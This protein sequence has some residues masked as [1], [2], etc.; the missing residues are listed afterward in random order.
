MFTLKKKQTCTGWDLSDACIER[1]ELTLCLLLLMKEVDL[2]ELLISSHVLSLAC[3][4]VQH[5]VLWFNSAGSLYAEV[6][7]RHLRNVKEK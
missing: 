2:D 1:H 5:V 7:A 6:L 3:N 4:Y